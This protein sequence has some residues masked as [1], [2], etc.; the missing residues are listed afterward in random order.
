MI[1]VRRTLG[2]LAIVGTM[3][4]SAC[5]DGGGKTGD[6][7]SGGAASGAAS[8]GSSVAARLC[9]GKAC[10]DFCI[11]GACDGAGECVPIF[12]AAHGAGEVSSN[13]GGG[14]GGAASEGSS[15]GAP[16]AVCPTELPARAS[17]CPSEGQRCSYPAPGC[18]DATN[19]RS[20]AVCFCGGWR[21]DGAHCDP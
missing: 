16:A 6:E 11:A 19:L 21:I 12:A 7:A 13:G 3:A 8:E 18:G 1:T 20:A 17:A 15:A 5:S 14:A 2:L 10:G 9:E 4:G